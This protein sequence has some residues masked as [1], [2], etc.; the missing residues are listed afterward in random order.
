M[1]LRKLHYLA[2]LTNQGRRV[3]FASV[4]LINEF[5]RL[6]L[7][8]AWLELPGIFG[9]HTTCYNRFVRWRRAGVWGKIMNTL[10]GERRRSVSLAMLGAP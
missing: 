3:P 6:G 8:A 9:L 2:G 10:A 4:S 5:R 7:G 1:G